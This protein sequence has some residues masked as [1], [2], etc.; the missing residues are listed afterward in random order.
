LRAEKQTEGKDGFGVVGK[1]GDWEK[2]ETISLT[3]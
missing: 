3:E 2:F 1:K